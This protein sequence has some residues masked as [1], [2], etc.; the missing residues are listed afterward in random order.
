MSRPNSRANLDKA[1]QRLA[2]GDR[3]G[4]IRVRAV[5]A[6]T[7][8]G[9][10]LPSGSVKG[11]S[12]I[13]LR[14]GDGATRFTTDL[15]VARSEA[16]D[17]F[18]EHLNVALEAGWSGFT[19][20]VVPGRPARPRD[21]PPQYVMQPF[22]V[23]LSYNGKSWLTVDL[24]IGH[25]E[26]GDADE[27]DWGISPDIVEL[28]ERLGFPSPDPIPLMPLHHQVAQKIH[29]LSEPGSKRAHDL[30]DL[31]LIDAAGEFDHGKTLATC[32]RLFAYR[33]RQ[34]W[35]SPIEVGEGWREAYDEQ[36]QGLAVLEDV[37][38]AV[39][40]ANALIKSLHSLDVKKEG[41]GFGE[42][43]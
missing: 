41:A 23:K 5:V 40:W 12:A 21:V 19:G 36:R 10:M 2:D 31:Q 29:A 13:K 43:R 30:I 3:D 14:L 38:D 37:E 28:F 18:V 39:A 22:E 27:P 34:P 11:G 24:E 32:K 16:L 17:D 8:V 26:I 42:D 15:D 20:R 33:K 25:N 1:L 7:V 6:N 9:Q 35:P 4:Y